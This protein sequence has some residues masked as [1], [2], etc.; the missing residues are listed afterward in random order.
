MEVFVV[1]TR[2]GSKIEFP[3]GVYSLLDLAYDAA[4]QDVLDAF[5][6]IKLGKTRITETGGLIERLYLDES[7]SPLI[8][9]VIR[10]TIDAE[11]TKRDRS[12]PW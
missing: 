11:P 7:G 2:I 4:E 6:T 5:P 9:Y 3:I 8:C 10:T 12:M 1:Y